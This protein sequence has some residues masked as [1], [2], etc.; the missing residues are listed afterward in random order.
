MVADKRLDPAFGQ[1]N[2]EFWREI[3]ML[4]RYKHEN[5]VSLLGFSDEGGEKLL[6]YEYLSNQSLDKY[7][8]STDLSWIQ[9]LNICIGAARRLEYLHNPGKTTYTVIS[10]VPTYC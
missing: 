8:S 3:I 5:P 6:V 2:P 9:R 10:R 7:L 4:T 1:G